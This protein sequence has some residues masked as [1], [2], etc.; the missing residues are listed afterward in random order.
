[1]ATGYEKLTMSYL[2][3]VRLAFPCHYLRALTGI[4]AHRYE[5]KPECRTEPK[6]KRGVSLVN[7]S[8]A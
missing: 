7:T 8:E 3:L 4:P 5:R 2:G 1:M 6:K